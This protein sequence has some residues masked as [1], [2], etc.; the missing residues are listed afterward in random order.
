MN[1]QEWE[2]INELRTDMDRLQQQMNNMQKMLETCMDMQI[3]L[4]HSVQNEVFAAL[5]HYAV[6]E[7]AYAETNNNLLSLSFFLCFCYLFLCY[8]SLLIR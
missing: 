5:N 1:L 7:G 8:T 3:E 6:S 4:Q 2:I